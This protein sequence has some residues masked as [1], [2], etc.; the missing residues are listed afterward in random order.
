MRNLN[1]IAIFVRVAEK[2]SFSA[3]AKELGLSASFVSKRVRA[4]EGISRRCC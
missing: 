1:D 2:K 3:A 4:L